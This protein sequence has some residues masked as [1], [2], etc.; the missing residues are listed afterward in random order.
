MKRLNQ[1]ELFFENEINLL[2]RRSLFSLSST[3]PFFE[4][5]WFGWEERREEELG[6]P[7]RMQN[8]FSFDFVGV[9]RLNLFGG[10]LWAQSAIGNQPTKKT[11]GQ[12]KQKRKKFMKH[13]ARQPQWEWS[14]A[15]LS[16]M[17]W[18]M[19]GGPAPR[20]LAHERDEQAKRNVFSSSSFMDG[21]R[22]I[23]WNPINEW[24]RREQ[25]KRRRQQKRERTPR[26]WTLFGWVMSL[27]L[28]SA[29][30]P[31]HWFHSSL[32]QFI[33]LPWLLRR[34]ETSPRHC[35][36]LLSFGA[37]PKKKEERRAG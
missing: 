27:P 35:S 23:E 22:L 8:E 32:N 26:G 10:G 4:N 5:G 19:A 3:K 18:V 34:K 15:W 21:M 2:C 20:Q 25:A 12:R 11:S 17:K 13:E 30:A 24:R 9:G 29:E 7:K 16:W 6:G 1:F 37:Q 31:I 14:L 36:S 33:W 28:I